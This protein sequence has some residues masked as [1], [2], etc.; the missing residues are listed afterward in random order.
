MESNSTVGGR[1]LAFESFRVWLGLAESLL[2]V[3][4][5]FAGG[6]GLTF[7][8]GGRDADDLFPG[9]DGFVCVLERF[10]SEESGSPVAVPLLLAS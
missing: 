2:A 8:L 10:S 3:G 5:R 4:V 7:P 1:L 9:R 6:R